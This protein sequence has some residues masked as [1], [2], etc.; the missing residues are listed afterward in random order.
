LVLFDIDATLLR[1]NGAG[2]AAMESAGKELFGDRFSARGIDFA[3]SLD[4]ILLRQMLL[5]CGVG[6]TSEIERNFRAVYARHLEDR[7]GT[8]AGARALDGAIELVGR[9]RSSGTLAAGL[10]TGNFEETGWLKLRACG[11]DPVWFTV[12]AWGNDSPHDPPDREHLP[13]VAMGRFRRVHGVP[14][15]P[16]RVTIIGDT[17]HDVRCARANGCRC[18]GVA[19]GRYSMQELR[20]AGADHAVPDLGAT[21]DILGMIVSV[22]SGRRG[23]S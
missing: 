15:E 17:I 13:P 1:T 21:S 9:V 10:L 12:C 22:P 8:Q 23:L 6:A 7:L 19:T 14:I 4:S 11:F 2:V 3:G 18:I 5:A 16:S 20:D